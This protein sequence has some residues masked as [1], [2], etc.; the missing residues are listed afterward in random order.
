MP[1]LRIQ[2]VRLVAIRDSIEVR[3]HGVV[4]T[5]DV[6]VPL[7]KAKDQELTTRL[8]SSAAWSE[9]SEGQASSVERAIRALNAAVR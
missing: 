9:L 8:G 5:P 4:V 2:R 3:Y 6:E 7:E 1:R